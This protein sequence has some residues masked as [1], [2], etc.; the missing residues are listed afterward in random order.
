MSNIDIST[1]KV[2]RFDVV[3]DP[4]DSLVV[5]SLDNLLSLIEA[6]SNIIVTETN[7]DRGLVRYTIDT[8]YNS[9]ENPDLINRIQE[10]VGE[11]S[12]TPITVSLDLTLLGNHD[13]IG[14]V[15]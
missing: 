7:L 10:L 9:D 14:P 11:I 13:N 8:I 12:Y 5:N 15:I 4:D 1:N 6:N 3:T 2:Y